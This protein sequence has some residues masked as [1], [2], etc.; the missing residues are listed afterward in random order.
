MF[1]LHMYKYPRLQLIRSQ[2]VVNAHRCIDRLS[3]LTSCSYQVNTGR[4]VA[5]FLVSSTSAVSA[6]SIKPKVINTNSS[7]VPADSLD[8]RWRPATGPLSPNNLPSKR[9]I[10]KLPIQCH[11]HHRSSVLQPP[12]PGSTANHSPQSH[13]EP[14]IQTHRMRQPGLVSKSAATTTGGSCKMRPMLI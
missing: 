5:T 4:T 8:P 10:R 14:P 2:I 6:L 7:Q 12:K 1:E 3:M 13:G 9:P 11:L